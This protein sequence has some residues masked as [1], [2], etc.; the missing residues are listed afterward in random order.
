MHGHP[1]GA[2]RGG[3]RGQGGRYVIDQRGPRFEGGLGHLGFAG[4]DRHPHVGRQ[5]LYHGKHPAQLLVDGNGIGARTGALAADVDHIGPVGHHSQA[6]GQG[7]IGI[8]PP[9]TVGE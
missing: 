1:A 9:A 3:H 7:S 8:E 2:G 5:G 6:V 4:V